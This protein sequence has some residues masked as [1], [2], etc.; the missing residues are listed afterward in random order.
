MQ[1]VDSLEKTLMLGGIGG[2]R[3]RGQPRMRWRDWGQEKGTTKDE[4]AGW[5]QQLD[6][7][8]FEWTPGVCSDSCPLSQWCHQTTSSFVVPFSCL[9]SFPRSVS[10]RLSQLFASGGQR[11]RASASV[12]PVNIQGWLS[13]G[14]TGW[15]SLMSNGLSRVFSTTT[16]KSTLVSMLIIV[17]CLA[18]L[19]T[20]SLVGQW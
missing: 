6:G 7:C 14:L 17:S 20:V 13:L 10:F 1:R 5:H 18:C 9:Q 8:E 2:R 19:L 16:T 12:L 3:R 15:I 11:I 4:M